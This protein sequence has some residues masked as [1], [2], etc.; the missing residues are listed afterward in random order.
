MIGMVRSDVTYKERPLLLSNNGQAVL[1]DMRESAGAVFSQG[2]DAR[3]LAIGDFDNDG[4]PDAIFTRL[5]NSPVLLRNNVA[6]ENSWIGFTL[7]E[8]KSNRDAIGAKLI[9]QTGGRRLV[10]WI[11]GGSSYLSSQDKRVIFGLGR[12]PAQTLSTVEIHWP[13]GHIQKI[14]GLACNRYHTIEEQR[15]QK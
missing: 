12:A 15:T 3:G 4:Y 7:R 11:T 2:Y 14:S 8:T 13:S 9:L 1:E 6:H 10:R 5:N